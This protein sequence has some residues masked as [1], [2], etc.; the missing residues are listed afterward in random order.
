MPL[1]LPLLDRDEKRE[2]SLSDVLSAY[3]Q[4]LLTV[5]EC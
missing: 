4:P 5:S 1:I 2:I 3:P